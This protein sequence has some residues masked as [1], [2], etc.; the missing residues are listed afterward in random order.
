[1]HSSN[2][3]MSDRRVKGFNYVFGALVAVIVVAQPVA[4]VATDERGGELRWFAVVVLIFWLAA[5]VLLTLVDHARL[6][7]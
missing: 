4:I 1:M 2:P 6:R 7:Q 3:S 5:A